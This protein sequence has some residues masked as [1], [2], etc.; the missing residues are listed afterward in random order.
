MSVHA[1][2]VG[3]EKCPLKAPKLPENASQIFFG[4]K[5]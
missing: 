3:V 1:A 5:L 4:E 2:Q